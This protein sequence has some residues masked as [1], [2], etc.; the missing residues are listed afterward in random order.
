LDLHSGYHQIKVTEHDAWKNSFKTKHG[1]FEWLVMLFGI[2]NSL[3]TFMHV[4]NDI[5][6]PF[7]DDFVIVYLDDILFF[8]GTWDEYVRHV[9]K[10]LDTLQR[11]K[12]YVKL[13]KCEFCKTALVYLG[14]IVGGGHLKID[15]S[16]IDVIVK[17][18]EPK[19][20]TEV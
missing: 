12:F 9:K 5:F 18:P 15:P 1:L 11:E 14:H 3:T 19:S 4:M 16:K 20:V 8:S 7:R 10:V 17:W 2:F 13:S 6:R